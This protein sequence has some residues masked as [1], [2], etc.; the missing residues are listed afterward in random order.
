MSSNKVYT[1]INRPKFP[2]AKP[3]IDYAK[4]IGPQ[5]PQRTDPNQYS[6]PVGPNPPSAGQK[7]GMFL[8]RGVGNFK[9]NMRRPYFADDNPHRARPTGGTSRRER[10]PVGINYGGGVPMMGGFG[11]GIDLSLHPDPMVSGMY[12]RDRPAEPHK[13]KKG[14][15]GTEIHYHYHY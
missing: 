13:K 7:I 9:E 11:G 14:G 5:Q 4:P 2:K 15:G 10:P 6:V 3:G 12:G 8:K 1:K